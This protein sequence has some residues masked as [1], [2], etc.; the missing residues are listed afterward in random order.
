MLHVRICAGGRPKGRS[1]PR[2]RIGDSLYLLGLGIERGVLNG[3]PLSPFL[4][5]RF[6]FQAG[7]GVSA[8]NDPL[9]GPPFSGVLRYHQISRAAGEARQPFFITSHGRLYSDALCRSQPTRPSPMPASSTA[10]GAGIGGVPPARAC[11]SS[12]PSFAPKYVPISEY[13]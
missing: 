8:H 6:A 13:R 1:L 5:T 12:G 9:S 11:H 7:N 4:P 10:P 3:G 2:H